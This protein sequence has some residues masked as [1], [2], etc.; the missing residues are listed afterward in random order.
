MSTSDNDSSDFYSSAIFA[1]LQCLR[2]PDCANSKRL[3]ALEREEEKILARRPFAK[4]YSFYNRV[5]Y[6]LYKFRANS[7]PRMALAH[8]TSMSDRGILQD[9]ISNNTYRPG[10]P[11][12]R[13]L[14][15]QGSQ[16]GWYTAHA[17]QHRVN[18]QQY[19]N[20]HLYNMRVVSQSSVSSPRIAMASPTS[21]GCPWGS[22]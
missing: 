17:I 10:M 9:Q 8:K 20:P 6:G 22:C 14:L 3:E 18:D 11:L 21:V 12:R 2:D 4:F 5:L 13:H 15:Q 1:R 19:Q 16:H 7:L